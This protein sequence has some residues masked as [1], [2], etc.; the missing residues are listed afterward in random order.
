[1]NC[2]TENCER[3]PGRNGYC[4]TCNRA[5]RKAVELAT[6]IVKV[7]VKKAKRRSDKRAGE[8]REY[9]RRIK[10]FLEGKECA[11]EGHLVPCSG[12]MTCHHQKGRIG[13]LL[14]DERYWLPVCGV[15]H[16]FIENNPE[17]AYR[18]G[19]S[20]LRTQ[21]EPHAI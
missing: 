1:M 11:L 18:N 5:A 10:V 14:L 17:T 16:A 9:L 19:W 6:R 8:E 3:L 12:R 13:Q 7:E 20:L 2:R 15:H 4:A 21:T